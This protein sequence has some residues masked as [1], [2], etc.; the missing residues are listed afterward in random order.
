MIQLAQGCLDNQ[1]STV[2]ASHC[3]LY[4]TLHAM[5]NKLLFHMHAQLLRLVS[6]YIN[7]K[8]HLK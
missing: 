1:G 4:F 2:L 3:L 7:I 5:K 8:S 6:H